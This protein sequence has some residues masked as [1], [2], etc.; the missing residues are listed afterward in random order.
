MKRSLLVLLLLTGG[1]QA[2]DV[3]FMKNGERRAGI[4]VGLE[5]PTLRLQ[6]P[7]PPAPSAVP[8]AAPVYASV[9]IARADVEQIG[10]ATDPARDALLRTATADKIPALEAQWTKFLPWLDMPRSPAARIG[11]LLGDLLLKSNDPTQ[12]SRALALFQQ[13]KDKAW[14]PADR[15]NARQGR[16]RAMVAT[17]RAAEA[18]NE[19]MELAAVTESPAV[20]I[21]AK[22][23]LAGA[24]DSGLRKLVEDNPRWQEDFFVRPEHARLYH[25]AVD[26]YLYPYLFHGSESEPAAR[27]LWGAA[28]VYDFVGEKALALECARDIVA[29]YPQTRYATQA[30]AFIASL[31]EDIRAADPEKEARNDLAPPADQKSASSPTPKPKKNEKKPAPKN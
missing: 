23:I 8:G 13:I 12:A 1:L 16:L 29:I 3:L 15:M 19:A 7:L 22:F 28:Q 30:K 31:P 17:G 11:V 26:L 9:G 20:L 10:F 25:G 24:D 4:L 6:V 2:E 18:V 27:G 5:G 14:D 21:E